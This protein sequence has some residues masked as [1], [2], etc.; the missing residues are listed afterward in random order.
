MGGSANVILYAG[1]IKFHDELFDSSANNLKVI[2]NFYNTI[3]VFL[4]LSSDAMGSDVMERDGIFRLWE[5][6]RLE[7]ML[8][9]LDP[10]VVRSEPML[11]RS[12]PI[13]DIMG[14]DT[15]AHDGSTW[16]TMGCTIGR[17]HGMGYSNGM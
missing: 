12:E 10:Q 4:S 2:S 15:M 6:V 13:W 7:P 17:D 5:P 8:D 1:L 11:V 9:H 3:L 14:W 16:D